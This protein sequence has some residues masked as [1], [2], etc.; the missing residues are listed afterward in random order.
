MSC[1]YS[2]KIEGWVCELQPSSSIHEIQPSSPIHEIQSSSSIHEIQP[3]TPI[4]EIQSS[5][6][7]HEIQPSTPNNLI[8]IPLDT[9][10]IYKSNEGIGT[11]LNELPYIQHCEYQSHLDIQ[12]LPHQ[13]FSC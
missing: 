6:P 4:H 12:I 5:T 11:I 1:T 10:Q 2:C 3:S 9:I 8:A 13:S 7:I